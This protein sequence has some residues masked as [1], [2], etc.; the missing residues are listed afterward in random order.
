MGSEKNNQYVIGLH[1]LIY[2]LLKHIL[3]IYCQNAL[4]P[5]QNTRAVVPVQKKP[6]LNEKH[7]Y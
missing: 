5:L 6:D 3:F 7:P 1:A 4:S 2:W